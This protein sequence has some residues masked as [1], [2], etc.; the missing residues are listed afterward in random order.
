MR[1]TYSFI[2]YMEGILERT[3]CGGRNPLQMTAQYDNNN[4]TGSFNIELLKVGDT[5][6]VPSICYENLLSAINDGYRARQ[7]NRFTMALPVSTCTVIK[8]TSD[9]ILSYLFGHSSLVCI[10]TQ[11]GYKYYGMNGIILDESYRPLMIIGHK[12]NL[13]TLIPSPV[14]FVSSK[15]YAKDDVLS[16]HIVKKIIPFC[17]VRNTASTTFTSKIEVIIGDLDKFIYTPPEPV[18]LDVTDT[19]YIIMR[20]NL[21]EI[22]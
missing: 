22:I 20:T 3:M 18:S 19:A 17:A 9:S 6:I 21:E 11:K 5:I 7:A 4:I 8:K 2:R 12:Y 16:K 10:D 1:L 15:V 13:D 14:C